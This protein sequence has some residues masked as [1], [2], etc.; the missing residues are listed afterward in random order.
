M[1]DAPI[2]LRTLLPLVMPYVPTCPEILA[3]Y[4][5]RL[6]AREFCERTSCWRYVVTQTLTVNSPEIAV[7][8]YAAVH[9][10]ESAYFGSQALAPAAYVDYAMDALPVSTT[11]MFV[12]QPNPDVLTILPFQAGDVKLTLIL[13][14]RLE[15]AFS[16]NAALQIEDSFDRVPT[17]MRDH[18]GEI[19]AAGAL[20]RLFLHKQDY[21]DPQMAAVKQ[22]E[23]ERGINANSF[24][25][26]QGQQ[27]APIR[28]KTSWV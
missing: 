19:I 9:K 15:N 21:G 28:S 10:I 20:A 16:T 8:A 11:P 13:K 22:G 18:Y 24:G 7:P 12:T 14:P 3:T 2:N 17:F 25:A 5:M 27:R 6:A 23:F 4:T 26:F 1:S